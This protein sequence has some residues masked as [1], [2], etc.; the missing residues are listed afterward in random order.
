MAEKEK[1]FTGFKKRI[2]SPK[3]GLS[4][5]GRKKI[6]R[7]QGSNLKPPVTSTQAKKSPKDA[8][9]RKSFCARFSGMKGPMSKEGKPTAKKAAL[10]RW[11]CG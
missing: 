1:P 11:D 8:A 9:R 2:N 5:D 7:E 6:N 3:G 4:E 10:D